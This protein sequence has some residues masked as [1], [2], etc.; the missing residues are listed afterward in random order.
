MEPT[1]HAHGLPSEPEQAFTQARSQAQREASGRADG[2]LNRYRLRSAEAQFTAFRTRRFAN[3]RNNRTLKLFGVSLLLASTTAVLVV[4]NLEQIHERA[5]AWIQGD[6]S[7][8]VAT[9][10]PAP[11]PTGPTTV[12]QAEIQRPMVTSPARTTEQPAHAGAFTMPVPINVGQDLAAIAS[13]LDAKAI[14]LPSIPTPITGRKESAAPQQLAQALRKQPP[15]RLDP[16]PVAETGTTEQAAPTRADE[17]AIDP[18]LRLAVEAAR[19]RVSSVSSAALQTSK[20][21]TGVFVELK[22]AEGTKAAKDTPASNPSSSPAPTTSAP[23]APTA[24]FTL[25]SVLSDG[26]LVRTGQ[27]VKPIRIGQELPDGRQL[28]AVDQKAGTFE[29]KK[30]IAGTSMP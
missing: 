10:G 22:K 2:I 14:T 27:Q 15:A 18:D 19:T 5:A 6:P 20:S 11:A 9:S 4:Q 17:P 3:L 1:H 16:L 7:G 26:V 12:A 25:V 13:P 24:R 30:Q 23:S 21:T 29:A 8:P 28:L